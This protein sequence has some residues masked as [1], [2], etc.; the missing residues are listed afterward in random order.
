MSVLGC[1]GGGG[2]ATGGVAC[3]AFDFCWSV[4]EGA[5]L[6]APEFAGALAG[7]WLPDEGDVEGNGVGAVT[8]T[9]DLVSVGVGAALGVACVPEFGVCGS[10]E[11]C[12]GSAGDGLAWAQ[13]SATDIN[14][15]A[16][17][18]SGER[19]ISLRTPVSNTG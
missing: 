6:V 5:A 1:A 4:D 2:G 3:W 12:F 17:N 11:P 14:R 15:K 19:C 8:G 10:P 7:C 9:P 18:A 13:L 16:S